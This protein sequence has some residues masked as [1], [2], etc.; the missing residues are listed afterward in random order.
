[1]VRVG[2]PAGGSARGEDRVVRGRRNRSAERAVQP[3]VCLRYVFDSV[4]GTGGVIGGTCAISKW[5]SCFLKIYQCG[6]YWI[7]LTPQLYNCIG[8]VV[9][10]LM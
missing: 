6:I 4:R 7:L 2:K 1:M 5:S 3:R 10:C 8:Y 9:A